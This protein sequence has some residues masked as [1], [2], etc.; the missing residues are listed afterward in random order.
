MFEFA[1]PP[2]WRSWHSPP[3]EREGLLIAAAVFGV[4]GAV[5]ILLSPAKQLASG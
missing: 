4:I 1:M 2:L 5:L 3:N